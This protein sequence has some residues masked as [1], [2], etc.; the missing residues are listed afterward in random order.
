MRKNG[1]AYISLEM[2]FLFDLKS[3][4]VGLD[5]VLALGSLLGELF[6]AFS[7]PKIIQRGYWLTL[8]LRK[9]SS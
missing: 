6:Y 5:L 8:V 4:V 3:S 2:L 7:A 9:L 1:T